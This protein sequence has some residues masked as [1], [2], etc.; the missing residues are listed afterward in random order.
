MSEILTIQAPAKLNLALAVGPPLEN[1]FHPICS[2]MVTVDLFDDLEV[3]RLEP[4]RLSR[5][6]ILWHEEAKRPSEID[7]SISKDL[8][9]RAHLALEK[10]LGRSLPVQ[11]KLDKRIPI[12]GGLGGGS[13]DAAATLHAVNQLFELGLSAA[14]LADI[15]AKLGSDVPFLVHGGSALVEGLGD[16]LEIH[17]TTPELHAV[18]ACPAAACPT[19]DVYRR[20]DDLPA[21]PIQDDAVRIFVGSAAKSP[22]ADGPFND[23]AEPAIRIAP[24][25]KDHLAALTK[26]AERP[27]HL[28]GSG[29]SIFV[30]CDDPMHAEF[31]ANAFEEQTQ[32]PTIAVKTIEGLARTPHTIMD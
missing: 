3:K 22:Q 12:G 14:E 15:G 16:K 4:D 2:W 24:E 5:Y 20:F 27:A 8:A 10:R 30:L 1:G 17:E 28:S 29:S 11:L 13:S 18:I 32:T 23:L 26:L 6:A 31:L 25:L 7:W 19:A 9:V 21:R